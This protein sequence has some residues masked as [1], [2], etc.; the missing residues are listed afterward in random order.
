MRT[1]STAQGTLL[2]ALGDPNGKE[3]KIRR[4]S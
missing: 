4:D 1:C 2:D 3:S